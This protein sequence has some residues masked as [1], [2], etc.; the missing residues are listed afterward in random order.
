MEEQLD[1]DI[2]R[3]A[4]GGEPITVSC[5]WGDQEEQVDTYSTQPLRDLRKASASALTVASSDTAWLAIRWR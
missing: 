5:L 1:I 3:V 2:A 4:S